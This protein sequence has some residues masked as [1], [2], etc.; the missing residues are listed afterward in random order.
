L[1]IQYIVCSVYFECVCCCC[2]A[3]MSELW[4]TG[5][6]IWGHTHP[7]CFPFIS[8]FHFV[9]CPTFLCPFP[10]FSIHFLS[11]SS[12]FFPLV[13]LTM[14]VTVEN[15]SHCI[16]AWCI[17]LI[18]YAKNF[19]NWRMWLEDEFAVYFMTVESAIICAEICS[20]CCCGSCKHGQHTFIASEV[21]FLLMM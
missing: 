14:V 16:L 17:L 3:F 12:T 9:P 10:P 15:T 8:K 18:V 2:I 5:S 7:S 19:D 1:A 20:I 6:W 11:L 21:V 13:Q 4:L